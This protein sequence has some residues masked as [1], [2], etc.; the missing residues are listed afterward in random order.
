MLFANI[1]IQAGIIAGVII[2]FLVTLI[3]NQRTKTPEGVKLPDKCQT[4]P[5]TSCVINI[6]K[7]DTMKKEV[8]ESIRNECKEE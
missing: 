1:F 3:L 2:L 7:V 5:S 4:C 8:L 6:Q